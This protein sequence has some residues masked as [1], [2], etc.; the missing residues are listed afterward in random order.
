M[1]R[2]ALVAAL[3]FLSS[4]LALA[5]AQK[6]AAPEAAKPEAQAPAKAAA[7]V[8]KATRVSSK[9]SRRAEDA[10]HCLGKASNNEIIK[11]AEEFL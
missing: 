11:C 3:M 7:Q 2:I 8:A 9:K 6:P 4:P 10:R 1:K 5:Q